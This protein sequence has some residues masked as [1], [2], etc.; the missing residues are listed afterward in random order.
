MQFDVCRIH[1]CKVM[2]ST[3]L[4]FILLVKKCFQN[5]SSWMLLNWCMINWLDDELPIQNFIVHLCTQ[6]HN[7]II[8]KYYSVIV[9]ALFCRVNLFGRRK[10]KRIHKVKPGQFILVHWLDKVIY[11]SNFICPLSSWWPVKGKLSTELS[12][13]YS[14][15]Q[16]CITY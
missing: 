3:S 8:A 4:F 2:H 10:I 12:T 15:L 5:I 16:L 9:L 13:D 14:F 11:R 6:K 7:C 1:L